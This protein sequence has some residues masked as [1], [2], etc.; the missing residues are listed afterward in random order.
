MHMTP[1]HTLRTRLSFFESLHNGTFNGTVGTAS[2]KLLWYWGCFT[3][4]CSWQKRDKLFSS[5]LRIG[6]KTCRRSRC[7]W[8]FNFL[9]T[10]KKGENLILAC[11]K[12]ESWMLLYHVKISG[13]VPLHPLTTGERM[14][15]T[16]LF[17]EQTLLKTTRKPLVTDDN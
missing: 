3:T 1:Q 9:V 12:Y 6:S 5:L 16:S 14:N 7:H 11:P 4:R 2:K 13:R 8:M 15:T 10:K 17:C